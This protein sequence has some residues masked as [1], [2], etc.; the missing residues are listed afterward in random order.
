MGIFGH[1]WPFL[2]NFGIFGASVEIWGVL[3]VLVSY[4]VTIWI[5]L[6][7]A[8]VHNGFEGGW[9]IQGGFWGGLGGSR[10]GLLYSYKAL[11]APLEVLYSTRFSS[12]HHIMVQLANVYKAG[13]NDPFLDLWVPLWKLSKGHFLSKQAILR[14]KIVLNLAMVTILHN[15]G[16]KCA[17]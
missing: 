15:N 16:L 13:I 6:V 17:L 4:E 7:V 2:D 10:G 12:K 14:S 11:F 9:G 5:R 1:F 3:G 8:R